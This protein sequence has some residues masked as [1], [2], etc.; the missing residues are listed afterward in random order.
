MH[1][2]AVREAAG[3]A[4]ARIVAGQ[5]DDG[6]WD[7]NLNAGDRN[8]LSYSTWCIQA[9]KAARLA[10]LYGPVV[11][12]ALARASSGVRR[13]QTSSTGR[14]GYT[15]PGNGSGGLTAAGVLCLQLLG[16]GHSP[17]VK[18]GLNYM[19]PWECRWNTAT[20]KSPLYYWYY[21]TQAKFHG[22]STTWTQWNTQCSNSTSVT[23]AW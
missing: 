4:I 1:Q 19:A 9:L 22:G 13:I 14:F 8:D 16:E 10:R 5:H 7:Y 3:R 6:G 23:S 21:A 18:A 17:A 12:R 20:V 2:P 11:D 15:A